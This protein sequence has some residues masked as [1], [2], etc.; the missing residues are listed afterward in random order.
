MRSIK[1]WIKK[2]ENDLKTSKDEMKDRES[3][4]RYYMLPY[5]AM[6]RKVLKGFLTI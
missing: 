3:R 4:N 5:A 1:D 2:S 6:C